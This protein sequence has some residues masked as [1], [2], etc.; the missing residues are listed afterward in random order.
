M[1]IIS[2][3]DILIQTATVEELNR[4]YKSM[5]EKSRAAPSDQLF[6][7]RKGDSTIAVVRL[8]QYESFILIRSLY[9]DPDQRCSGIGTR[10]MSQVLS[11]IK[12]TDSQMVIAIPTPVAITLYQ[13]LGF[14]PLK[15]EAIPQQLQ[16]AYRRVR[17][18]D[19]GAPVMA[20]QL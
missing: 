13:K 5:A 14:S 12:Q 3:S 2:Q 20:I 4:F 8:L 18:A 9:V 17:R 11:N 19:Q 7:A 6:S 15:P 10:L 1:D 16:S